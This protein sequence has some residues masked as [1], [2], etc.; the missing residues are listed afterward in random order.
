MASNIDALKR[1]AEVALEKLQGKRYFAYD[2]NNRL[3]KAANDYRGDAVIQAMARVVEKVSV[4]NP[5]E[6][7]SQSDI[8]ELYNEVIGLNASGTKCREVLGDLF[9]SKLI[10]KTSENASM[11]ELRYD[12]SL[13]PISL[14][15]DKKTQSEMDL[16]FVA[17]QKNYDQKLAI[18]AKNKV[19]AELVS[20]GF[21]K[22]R[23]SL[24]GGNTQFVVFAADLDTTCGKV[25]ILV[26][27]E[28]T[29]DKFPTVFMADDKIEDLTRENIDKYLD[30]STEMF[31]HLPVQSVLDDVEMPRANMPEPLKM[32]ASDLEQQMFE[33]ALGYPQKSVQVAKKMVLSEL[34][35]M[36]FKGSQIRISEP[37]KD[38]FICQATINT[39]NGKTIIEIPIEM[40]GQVPLLP[41]VFA[42]GD[43]VADFNEKNLK[44]FAIGAKDDGGFIQRD[45]QLYS[46]DLYQLKDIV[47]KAAIKGDFEVCNDALDVI[48]DTVDESTYRSVVADYH[49]M[50]SNLKNGKEIIQQAYDD[51]DQFVRTPT[52]IYPI[53]KKFGRPAHEL[54]RDENGVYHLKAT[55]YARQNQDSEGAFF[56]T[57][58]VLVG[59]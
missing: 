37:T 10:A 56:S 41:S 5:N 27:T 28:A 40:S 3:Q 9:A 49:K 36:G 29:G 59:D 22:P 13:K 51:S 48:A 2:L 4:S 15:V 35:N 8:E 33:T 45:C 43:Y 42:S 32:I 39:A 12:P 18:S 38:G 25:R 21:A 53:H 47:I 55:Y 11:S 44:A 19:E 17:P 24:A 30:K 58:K 52:S 16:L 14:D 23:I 26:P 1:A 34:Y 31:N 20:F 7:I 54:V 6:I 50:L 46:M 57:A